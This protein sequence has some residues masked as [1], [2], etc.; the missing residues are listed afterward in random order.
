VKDDLELTPCPGGT[1]LRL[2]VKAGARTTAIVGVHGG[3]L[4]VSVTAAAERG[5]ANREVVELLAN[6]LGLPS[7]AVTITAGKSSQDKV[8]EIAASVAAVC[9]I[10]AELESQKKR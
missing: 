9:G 8:V 5:K 4:K 2:R 3:A 1:R 10:L 7:S 6:T